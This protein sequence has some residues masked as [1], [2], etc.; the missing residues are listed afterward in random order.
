VQLN[1]NSVQ[2]SRDE[3]ELIIQSCGETLSE[4]EEN[5]QCVRMLHHSYVL[6]ATLPLNAYGALQ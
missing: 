2:F 4:D 3:I 6:I 5:V 1:L